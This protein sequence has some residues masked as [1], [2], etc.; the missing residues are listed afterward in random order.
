[1]MLNYS[2]KECSD[3]NCGSK[4]SSN[5]S[6]SGLTICLNE[7]IP[8]YGEY[9]TPFKTCVKDCNGPELSGKLFINDIQNKKC[10][11][12]NFYIIKSSKMECLPNSVG[13]KK[14]KYVDNTYNI[15]VFNTKEC[16]NSCSGKILSPSEDTCYETSYIKNDST[17]SEL[18]DKN[19]YYTGTKCDCKYNFYY[20]PEEKGNLKICLDKNGECPLEYKK[21]AHITKE[22][23]KDCSSTIYTTS[24]KNLCINY[25][26][27]NSKSIGTNSLDCDTNYYSWYYNEK[28]KK[29]ECLTTCSSVK[30]LDVPLTKTSTLCLIMVNVILVVLTMIF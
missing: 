15:N 12:E 2:L 14:C 8:E 1:M 23:V 7:C 16:I 30:Y 10:I 20:K 18:V 17:C 26:P 29:Y 21:Y 4:N 22:C 28:T 27:S 19:S 11:C 24:F 6:E 13:K 25:T 3:D 5:H 9:L